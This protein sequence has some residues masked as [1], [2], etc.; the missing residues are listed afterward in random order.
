[1]QNKLAIDTLCDAQDSLVLRLTAGAL[2]TR[3]LT[4]EHSAHV[5]RLMRAGFSF[6]D[7]ECCFWDALAMARTC[8]ADADAAAE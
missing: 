7:A 6:N 5:A 1:M 8:R 4:A 3:R 2:S